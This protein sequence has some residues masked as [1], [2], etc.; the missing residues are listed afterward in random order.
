MNIT[1]V[2]TGY[3]GLVVGA[4]FAE[5]G[6]TVICV[7]KDAAKVRALQKGKIPMWVSDARS[8]AFGVDGLQVSGRI[9]I[10]MTQTYSWEVFHQAVS[11]LVRTGQDKETLVY[12]ILATDTIDIAI[13]AAVTLKEEGNSGLMAAIKALRQLNKNN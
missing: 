12:R 5:N 10:W 7:D 11:R 9:C 1:V 4:C 8:L 2:G 3:V 6:N 13:V